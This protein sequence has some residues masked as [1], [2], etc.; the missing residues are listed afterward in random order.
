MERKKRVLKIKQRTCIDCG[1]VFYSAA[2]NQKR[3]GGVEKFLSCAFKYRKIRERKRRKKQR[4]IVLEHYSNGK[5]ECACCGE[6]TIEF[7]SIDHINGGGTQHLKEIVGQLT[8][9]LIKNKFPSGFQIL[10]HNCNQAKGFYGQCPHKAIEGF[11]QTGDK[12][13]T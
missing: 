4:K 10:C 6:T 9:W 5:M 12:S 8:S 1:N 13:G 2:T 11:P 3:C 7:L